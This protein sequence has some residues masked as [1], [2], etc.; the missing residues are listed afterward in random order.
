MLPFAFS[1]IDNAEKGFV[2]MKYFTLVLFFSYLGVAA[3][4][5]G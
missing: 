1:T 3:L 4:A 5:A 2:M